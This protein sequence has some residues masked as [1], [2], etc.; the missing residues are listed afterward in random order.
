MAR[1]V[2]VRR[3]SDWEEQKLQRIARRGRTSTVRYRAAIIVLAS[4]GGN[5]VPVIARLV[6]AD[7]D[8]ARDVIHKFNE[9]GLACLDPRWAGGRPRL[10]DRDDE[11]FVIETATTR[12]SLLGL[13][14][15]HWSVRKL[16]TYLRRAPGRCIRIGRETLRCL[17]IRRQITFQRTKTWK[18]STDPD[19]DAK[20][21]RIEYALYE[22]PDRT[23]AFDEFGPLGIR[24]T[25]GTCWARQ[26]KPDRLPATFHRTHGVRYFH[27]CYS[28]GDDTLWGTNR[29]RK[30]AD[31][32]LAALKSIRAAR[33]DGAPI[34]VILDNLSAHKGSKIRRWAAKN[35]VE[36]CFTPTNASWANPIES[37]FGPLRQFTLANS[38]HPNHT[39]QTRALHCHL[40]WRNQNARHP[41]VLA[42]QRRERARI[43]SE[44]GIRW[45]GRPAASRTRA[46]TPAP[47]RPWSRQA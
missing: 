3:L 9:T 41:D 1:L 34:Y 22:R 24:P 37:H 7:E 36:L 40:R 35:K 19:F 29:C 42:A 25:A 6:Q 20:L 26:S 30:G 23:F 32:S 31:H 13:P 4:A 44:K 43:R 47:G 17:L 33:P 46:L 11:D 8:T 10:L 45:G 39:V 15:T 38:N 28:V 5:S 18:E 27:G 21:D 12:P 16:A 2:R 14:F